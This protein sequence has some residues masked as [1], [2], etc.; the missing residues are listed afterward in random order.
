MR[1]SVSSTA[2]RLEHVAQQV[3][4]ERAGGYDALLGEGDRGGLHRTD[5]DRQVPLPL[6]LAQQHDRLV[7]RHLDADTHDVHL[8]HATT[9]GPVGVHRA[10]VSGA[11]LRPARP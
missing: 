8:V 1:T 6:D 3:V 9:L 5:P 4:R 10:T 11:A 2:E 7:R